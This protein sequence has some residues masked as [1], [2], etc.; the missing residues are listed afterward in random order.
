MTSTG[1]GAPSSVGGFT[2]EL[3]GTVAGHSVQ[4][5]QIHGG[6]TFIAAPQ[7]AS[8]PDV[9]PDQVPPVLVPFVNRERDLAWLDERFGA[10]RSATGVGL[11]LVYGLRGVGKTSIVSYWAERG[12]ELFP[13]G[14]LYIDFALL[15]G[16]SSGADVSEA[17]RQCLRGIGVGETA[18]PTAPAERAALFRS[19]SAGR[20]LLIVCEN[21]SHPSQVRSLV[22]K[23]KGSVLLATSH[24]RLGEL[25]MAGAGLLAMEPFDTHSGLQLLTDRCGAE[26]VAAE[27]A[28][29]EKL[30]EL[31]C[32]LPE[33]LNVVAAKLV[34]SSRLTMTKL[35]GE[36]A[37][38]TDRLAGMA[39]GEEYSVSA[40]FDMTYRELPTNA[41][42]VYRV[43]GLLPT[44]R[45]DAATLAVAAETDA[46]TA[47]QL[48]DA[49]ESA[50]L[51]DALEDDRY[52]IHDLVRLHAREKAEAE[53]TED[54]QRAVV[55]RVVTHYLA[56]T[57]LAD[58][59]L[60]R[61]RLRIA[62]LDAFLDQVPDPFTEGEG[63]VSPL[64]WLEAE[65]PAI[66]EVLRA[67]FRAGL[68]RQVWQLSEAFTALFLRHRHLASW[69]ESLELGVEAVAR[70][71]RPVTAAEARLRSLL[72]RPLMD[73]GQ[74]DAARA[75]LDKALAAAEASGD[76]VVHA[77]V[78]E[79]SGRYWE[80]FAP[81]RALAEYRKAADLNRREEE[82]RG[83][84]IVTYFLGCTQD[85]MGDH[86]SAL[87]TLREAHQGLLACEDAR[88]AARALLA[89]GQVH[90]HLGQVAEARTVLSEAAEVLCSEKAAH[91]E[92]QA[93]VVLAEVLRDE[94]ERPSVVKAQVA[95]AVE[96]YEAEGHPKAQE[97]RPWLDSLTGE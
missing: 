15:G 9:K 81:A 97:L 78:L 40:V 1:A 41:A 16:R 8:G 59:A 17:V 11:G 93:R 46:R 75:E 71:E 87:E 72:S 79:F 30:V 53:E 12:R 3:S 7:P 48:L 25:A 56:L 65:H 4:A 80:R 76:A 2:N 57:A 18:I 22:P 20:R 45:F 6:I 24:L 27:R 44:K 51:V 64:D 43:I 70:D 68:H 28:A 83:A 21:V 63:A 29:A 36:L 92:A 73:L 69:K 54:A 84:A 39:L 91:Y 82:W 86:T 49:L 85:T 5:Q 77:S 14:Q 10:G 89:R 50:R 67:A 66:L 34:N 60:R 90:A 94:G 32:G 23:G 33:A 88:M 42:R 95:R 47:Q 35:A 55:E 19:C 13:D 58:R 74:Y 31:S 37:E 96:I 61:D 62:D 38:E 26:A 52:R